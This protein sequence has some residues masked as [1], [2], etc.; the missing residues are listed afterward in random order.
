MG[1]LPA[2][3]WA[4]WAATEAL[5][6]LSPRD[7]ELVQSLGH[8][9]AR[10]RG[11]HI[12]VDVQYSAVEA[13]IER[14]TRGVAALQDA[15]GAGGLLARVAQDWVVQSKG[16]CEFAIR[17]GVVDARREIGNVERSDLLAA[18]TER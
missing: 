2:L 7:L 1:C 4:G 17:L 3:S 15:I 9:A 10:C 8:V 5:S 12:A 11:V 13:D 6:G 18:R 14:A 16:F